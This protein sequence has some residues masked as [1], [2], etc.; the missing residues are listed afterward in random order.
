MFKKKEVTAE[1]LQEAKNWYKD[2]YQ[3]V[4]V[5]RNVLAVTTLVALCSALVAVGAVMLLTPHKSVEPFVIQ[6]D[7][8][9]GIVQKVEPVS[10][11]EFTSNESIDRFFVAQ[12][13]RSRETYNVSTFRLNYDTVRVMSDSHVFGGYLAAI[14]ERNPDSAAAILKGDGIRSVRFKS[15]VFVKRP[16]DDRDARLGV[17]AIQARILLKDMSRKFAEPY[18][19][20]RVATVTFEYA[21]LDLNEEERY[22]NPLGFTVTDYTIEEEVVR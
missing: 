2:K 12:Y 17:K 14:S 15:I 3:Y 11:S 6:I 10:R 21:N 7:Q 13:I 22:L 18:E 20:H 4:L 9:S 8:K 5:Q 19:Y 1:S 16:N